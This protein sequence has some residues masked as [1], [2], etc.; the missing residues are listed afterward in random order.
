MGDD[1]W[2]DGT[3]DPPGPREI[4][5]K[6]M[7]KMDRLPFDL[8]GQ[9][10]AAIE[11]GYL[12]T[13]ETAS[14]R[15]RRQDD[16]CLLTVKTGSDMVR[17]EYEIDLDPGRFAI[18]WPATSGRRLRKVRYRLPI[19]ER[20][21]E[22]DIFEGALAGLALVEVE[23]PDRRSAKDFRPPAW[24]GREV[25]EAPEYTNARLASEGLPRA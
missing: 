15:L 5:R 24:F 22:L 19:G 18:L 2:S 23:F 13:E 6:F 16:R 20:T 8:R 21:A 10:G 25:T 12:A 14:V 11:Q 4:E 9:V 3:T 1:G 17:G 7:V